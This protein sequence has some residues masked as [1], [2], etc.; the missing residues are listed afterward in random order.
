[1][2]LIWDSM[3]QDWLLIEKRKNI[4][5]DEAEFDLGFDDPRLIKKYYRCKKA[6]GVPI[7]VDDVKND[8]ISLA[9]PWLASRGWSIW[10][11]VDKWLAMMPIMN[12]GVSTAIDVDGV[13]RY[14]KAGDGILF[15]HWMM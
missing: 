11:F 6:C 2:R 1:M 15:E 3:T 13:R 4:A 5:N 12:L 7:L 14:V 10:R 9:S 8:L